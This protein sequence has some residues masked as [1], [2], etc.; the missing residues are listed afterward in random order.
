MIERD[1]NIEDRFSKSHFFSESE[2]DAIRDFCQKRQE[3]EAKGG[4]LLP[5]NNQKEMVGKSTEY[6]RLTVIAEYVQWLA[7]MLLMNNID[8]QSRVEIQQMA[9]RLKARRP[10]RRNRNIVNDVKGLT[11]EHIEVAFEV[12]RPDSPDNPFADLGVRVR[13]RLIFLLLYHLGL[14]GGEL[15]NIRINDFDFQKNQLLIP[16]RADELGDPRTYQP[17]VKTMDRVL[18]IKDRLIKAVHGYILTQRKAVPRATKN[19]YLLVT[20]KSGPSQGQP[21]SI[22]GYK[23]I[24]KVV[25]KAAPDLYKF[26]GHQLRHTWNENFSRMMDSMDETPSAEKQEQIRSY[27]MG[28]KDGSGTA[29]TYNKRFIVEKAHEAAL[30]QQDSMVRLPEGV[31][32]D[33]D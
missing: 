25:K 14:R 11:A 19:N 22:S 23:R 31:N 24:I 13:N 8:K 3:T 5:E 1:E 33:G 17:L 7:Q 32:D 27:L 10:P 21:L 29:A 12:F 15:L 18:P 20:H 4:V 2:L 6:T 26:T 16:R 28:W 9:T 30:K